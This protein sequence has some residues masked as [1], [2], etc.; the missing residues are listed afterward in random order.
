VAPSSVRVREPLTLA[1]ALAHVPLTVGV[2]GKVR[3]VDGSVAAVLGEFVTEGAG[4]AVDAGVEQVAVGAE[5][6]REAAAGINARDLPPM[7]S[8]RA[9]CSETSATVRVHVGME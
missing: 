1:T 8:R 9:A 3:G 6:R 2:G 5:L 7:A 4:R